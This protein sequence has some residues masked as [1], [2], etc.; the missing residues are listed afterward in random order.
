LSIILRSGTFYLRRRV[1]RQFADIEEREEVWL[2]LKTDSKKTA[3]EKAKVLWDALLQAWDARL[4]GQSDDAQERFAAARNIAASKGLHYLPMEAVVDLPKEQLLE[5]IEALER[6]DSGVEAAAILGAVGKPSITV[7][8]ALEAYWPI[9]RDKILGKSDDQI[10][11]WE[12]PRKKAIGNFVA[13]CGD[14]QLSDLTADHM[15]EFRGWWIDG[16]QSKRLTANSANKDFIHFKSILRTV[17]EMKKLGHELPLGSLVSFAEGD[18]EERPSFSD[19]WIKEK[20]LAPGALNGLNPEARAILLGMINTGYRPSEGAGL[21]LERINLEANIPHIRIAPEANREIK[22]KTSKRTIPLAGV[23]L[24]AFREFP[25]GFPTYREKP[26]SLSATVNK[27]LKSNGLK[28]TDKHVF[29]SLRH[30]FEDRLLREGV[31][32]RVRRDFLGHALDREKYGEG[33]GL[34]FQLKM[35]K[36]VAF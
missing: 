23:S 9:T 24:E 16:L 12:N 35:I 8:M 15:L 34:A 13:V 27:F 18:A 36:R 17:N 3:Q 20:L 32:E 4:R 21:T 6:N 14:V 31:D 26:A 5:R 7:S 30:S 22:N 25:N 19:Q 2:S 28:E 10:R 11:R 1:P 29:Y 33:G